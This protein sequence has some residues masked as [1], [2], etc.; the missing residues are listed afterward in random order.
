M[1][2]IVK[3][4]LAMLLLHVINTYELKPKERRI[5]SNLRHLVLSL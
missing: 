5:I 1:R 3:A 4:K 2:Y